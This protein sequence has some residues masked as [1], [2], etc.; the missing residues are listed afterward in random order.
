MNTP[1]FSVIVVSRNAGDKLK[2][3][4]E[5]ILCQTCQDLEVIIKDAGSTDGSLETIPQDPRIRLICRKDAGIYDG[6][7]EALSCAQGEL[8][9]FLNCGDV[10]HDSRVLAGVRDA[11]LSFA[12][13]SAIFYGDVIEE[14]TGQRVAAN[15]QMSHFAMYRYLPCHQ[16]CFYTRDLF[17]KRQFD[18]K[19]LVRAD[20]EHFLYCV[21]R[22][23]AK[24]TCLPLVIADYEGGGFS[25]TERGRA[26][27]D[28]EHRIITE[29]YFTGRERALYRA[30][31]VVSLQPL[32]EKLATGKHTAAIYDAVKNTVYRLRRGH[33]Q[34]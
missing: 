1:Y 26:L 18:T 3:T 17:A 23:G 30:Y 25:E 14:R 33:R 13:S 31:L 28:R 32:R 5:S 21:M 19:Y 11:A 2:E 8:I 4:V 24:T 10:L 22:E 15:P 16:A 7:N 34:N 20:Y 12:G 6:M 9:Y 29:Q 27:S